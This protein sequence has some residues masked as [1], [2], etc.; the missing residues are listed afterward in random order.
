MVI[1]LGME[2][3][4]DIELCIL[5]EPTTGLDP[6]TRNNII[7]ILSQISTQLHKTIFF[8]THFMDDAEECDNVIILSDKKIAAQ[9]PPLKL[10]K[11]LPGGGKVVNVILDNVT[12][13]L[14]EKIQKIEGIKKIVREG[15]NLRI[16]TDDPNAIKLGQKI[17][18]IGGVVNE[19]K[20]DRATMME[21]FVYYTGKEP[22]K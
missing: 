12:D 2:L 5:D 14:L 22:E 19:T 6:N 20:I 17:D 13:D 4:R 8:T 7:T 3:I 18:E 9:G 21:V 16:L 11:M 15:R 10:E 1:S